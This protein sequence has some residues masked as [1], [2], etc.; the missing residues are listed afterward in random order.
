LLD[1]RDFPLR[2]RRAGVGR[3]FVVR[4]MGR[5]GLLQKAGGMETGRRAGQPPGPFTGP[6]A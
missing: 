6:D 1:V 3:F 5:A 4:A 2:A